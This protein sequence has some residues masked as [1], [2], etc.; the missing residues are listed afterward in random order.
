MKVRLISYTSQPEKVV[1]T[2]AKLCYSNSK[3]D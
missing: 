2:A 1:A 3:G